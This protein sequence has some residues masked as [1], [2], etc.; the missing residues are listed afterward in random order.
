V[1]AGK[2]L[3]RRLEITE[4]AYGLNNLKVARVLDNLAIVYI[5]QE[6]YAKAEPFAKRTLDIREKLLPPEHVDLA[7]SL[8]RLAKCYYYLGEYDRAEPLYLR[9]IS[10]SQKF[11]GQ[12]SLDLAWYTKNYALLLYAQNKNAQAE[13]LF[14]KA[15]EMFAQE[16]RDR[17]AAF[18]FYELAEFYRRQ[19]KYDEAEVWFNKAIPLIDKV[20][21]QDPY[22]FATILER[23]A[24]LLRDTGRKTEAI[25]I[26]ERAK[27]LKSSDARK[28]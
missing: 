27:L 5:A 25:P 9:V 19:K 13:S 18:S 12:S 1:D 11:Q 20:P 16:K 28:R 17:D 22:E 24:S 2:A 15:Q 6:N 14:Q 23:Y 21:D 8:N 4:R 10:L 7:E 26:E 3:Q